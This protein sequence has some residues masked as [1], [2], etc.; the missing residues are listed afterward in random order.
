M[1]SGGGTVASTIGGTAATHSWVYQFDTGD[2]HL[3]S[4]ATAN[5]GVT[6]YDLF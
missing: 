3:N 2:F 5:D 4:T 1:M 6:T